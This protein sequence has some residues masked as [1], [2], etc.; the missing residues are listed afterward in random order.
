[1]VLQF[2]RA[3]KVNVIP[4]V[5]RAG[6]DLKSL[7][8]TEVVELSS[9][10]GSVGKRIGEITSNKGINAVIDN[11]GG[12]VT[13]ELIRSM[14]FGGQVIIN[15]GMSAERFELH[16]FDVLLCGIEIRS[17]VYRYFFTPPQPSEMQILRQIAEAAASPQFKVP[18]GGLNR[19]ED[20]KSAIT[21][22]LTLPGRGKQFFE[23]YG[24]E[25]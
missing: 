3:R 22:T 14:A 16:N 2:A 24:F 7:G 15:G 21:E 20:F 18:V 4:I 17:H 5:R 12:P 9:L 10:D 23:I 13:G 19:L 11:V 1:M 8:A 25:D 6:F